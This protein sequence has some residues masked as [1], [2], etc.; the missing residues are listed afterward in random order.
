MQFGLALQAV[1]L[2]AL[3]LIPEKSMAASVLCM[4]AYAAGFGIFKPFLD[5]M[6][7]EVSEG[8]ERAGFYSMINTVICAIT[9]LLGFVSGS[10][11]KYDPRLIYIISIAILAASIALLS[12]YSRLRQKKGREEQ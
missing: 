3:I 12:V 5:S 11:Y 4:V 2:A 8:K 10:I 9:A 1:S 7:A 6:L